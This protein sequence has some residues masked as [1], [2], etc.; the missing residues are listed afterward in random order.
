MHVHT[1]GDKALRDDKRVEGR[2]GQVF[3]E[4]AKADV[5]ALLDRE[6]RSEG[7]STFL[8]RRRRS[9]S[10]SLAEQP[11]FTDLFGSSHT[12]L[13][14]PAYLG[15]CLVRPE[16]FGALAFSLSFFTTLLR[17]RSLPT[18]QSLALATCLGQSFIFFSTSFF[19]SLSFSASILL[20]YR[21]TFERTAV[22]TN[23]W[24]F[25][26]SPFLFFFIFFTLLPSPNVRPRD[27]IL[28]PDARGSLCRVVHR[29]TDW[30]CWRKDF[31]SRWHWLR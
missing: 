31:F 30:P 26:L 23:I 24:T 19:L 5:S 14:L 10:L 18:L 2:K 29:R 11:C 25:F 4:A 13:R 8:R 15:D 9:R 22:D 7:C 21:L 20:S 28:I 12:W 3:C 17:S 1:S 27:L 6:T 16:S